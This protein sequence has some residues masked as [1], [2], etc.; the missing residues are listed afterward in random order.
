MVF[1]EL[2][3]ITTIVC[4]IVDI[5]DFV[6]SAKQTLW[7]WVFGK[8]KE[9][10]EFRLKPFDCSLC[11]SFWSGLFYLLFVGQLNILMIGYVCL[12]SM[13]SGF[14]SKVLNVMV[15]MCEWVVDKIL[16]TIE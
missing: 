15:I 12:L 16:S 14:I 9:Y 4:Y 1:I 11:L 5:T 10:R 6:G 7:K 3:V 2:L 13:F 8:N